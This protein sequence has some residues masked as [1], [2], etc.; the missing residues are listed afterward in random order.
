LA[1]AVLALGLYPAPLLDVMH[2]TMR[3]LVDQAL[4]TKIPL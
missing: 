3:H 4:A 1:L 2:A